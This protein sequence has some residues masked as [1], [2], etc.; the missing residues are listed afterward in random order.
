MIG[1]SRHDESFWRSRDNPA[2]LEPNDA[3][4][5]AALRRACEDGAQLALEELAQ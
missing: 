5:G 3:A 1:V 2:A 4:I